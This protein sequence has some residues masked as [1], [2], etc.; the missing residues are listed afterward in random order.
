MNSIYSKYFQKSRSFLYPIL[1]IKKSSYSSPTG[2]YIAIQGL[3]DADD[4]KLICTFKQEETDKF[5]NFEEQMLITNPL[6]DRV[7]EVDGYK[8]YIFDLK[9]YEADWFNFLL[10]KYSKL[11]T[12]FKKAIKSFYGENSAEY[13]FMDS[14]L[15]PE[16]YFDDY[17]KI[18]DVSVSDLKRIGELCD[19]CDLDKE[20]L[21]VENLE[22]SKKDD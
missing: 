17:A 19:P 6:F 21:V 1:G 10:G 8:L 22:V 14:Y 3:I 4:V 11:S 13:K 5:K 12:T 7:L 15:Y 9:V 2:T 16:K 20:T 18:L